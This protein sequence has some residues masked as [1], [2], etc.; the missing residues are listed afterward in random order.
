[1][2]KALGKPVIAALV[3]LRNGERQRSFVKNPGG[4]ARIL[5]RCGAARA[6][7][8]DTLKASSVAS[9]WQLIRG[10]RRIV[11]GFSKTSS[12]SDGKVIQ[13]NIHPT[14]P[15]VGYAH[16]QTPRSLICIK[17]RGGDLV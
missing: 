7:A 12:R 9:R 2:A 3:R 5:S 10:D 6:S 4:R 15:P 8:A 1:M 11:I 17:A 14:T 16:R 13:S